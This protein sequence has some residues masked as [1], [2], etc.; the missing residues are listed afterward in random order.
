MPKEGDT[1]VLNEE[2]HES[3]ENVSRRR[4]KVN[5]S[6][7]KVLDGHYQCATCFE[8]VTNCGSNTYRNYTYAHP[9]CG[10]MEL[11]KK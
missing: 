1:K 10:E 7:A 11:V 9:D 4:P 5:K 3:A 2:G 6:K 8:K